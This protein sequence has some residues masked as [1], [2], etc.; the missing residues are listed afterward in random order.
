MPSLWWFIAMSQSFTLW[1]PSSERN[2][3]VAFCCCYKK[4]SFQRSG[5]SEGNQ[6]ICNILSQSF[7]YPSRS[8]LSHTRNLHRS[9]YERQPKQIPQGWTEST[10]F[11]NPHRDNTCTS[12]RWVSLSH[13]R[14][15]WPENKSVL[16][17]TD[18]ELRLKEQKDENLSRVIFARESS[19]SLSSSP[20]FPFSPLRPISL[21]PLFLF[22]HA[23]CSL[24]SP[25]LS[26][27]APPPSLSFYSIGLPGN[28]TET[29]LKSR[30]IEP[31]SQIAPRAHWIFLQM[32]N[33]RWTQLRFRETQKSILRLPPVTLRD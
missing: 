6:A 33:K 5:Y 11:T 2:F 22:P 15:H 25:S 24:L 26:L 13:Y 10:P 29:S 21:I 14:W 30:P 8:I 31:R 19:L 3:I 18:G 1:L 28:L 16:F 20:F 12:H 4:H 23:F 9:L 17:L 7:C 27:S 32:S